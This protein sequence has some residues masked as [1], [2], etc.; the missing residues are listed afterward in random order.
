MPQDPKERLESILATALDLPAGDERALF[1]E[2]ECGDEL[3]L[4][5][6]RVAVDPDSRVMTQQIQARLWRG[7]DVIQEEE[8]TLTM[9]L[10]ST[11]ELL[12]MLRQT[13]FRQVDVTDGYVGG[14]GGG[15]QP[16]A[17]YVARR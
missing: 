3:E 5:T 10:F 14:I 17:V 4:R 16:V 13:G 15:D 2:K 1:V 12:G 8:H 11:E 9:G 6:R 7:E